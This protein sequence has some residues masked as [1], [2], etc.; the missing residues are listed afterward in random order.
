M[1][2]KW[3]W[4][5][6]SITSHCLSG[7]PLRKGLQS[8][9]LGVYHSIHGTDTMEELFWVKWNINKQ[10]TLQHWEGCKTQSLKILAFFRLKDEHDRAVFFW[11]LAPACGKFLCTYPFSSIS[12]HV[13]F[14]T[15]KAWHSHKSNT[16]KPLLSYRHVHNT[17]CVLV[18]EI[19]CVLYKR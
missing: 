6:A 3:S 15:Y 14:M 9:P 11:S 8:S 7:T 13:P 16:L 17:H 4:S 1:L 5:R 19:F 18:E 2:V 12:Q 10:W